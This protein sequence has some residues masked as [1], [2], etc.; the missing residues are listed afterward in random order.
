MTTK[1]IEQMSPQEARETIREMLDKW[2][3]CIGVAMR[4]GCS[5][6]QAEEVTGR[7]FS[8]KFGICSICGQ[9]LANMD[10][11]VHVGCL[12]TEVISSDATATVR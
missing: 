8:Y 2:E 6:V 5:R 1:G 3:Y 7:Y 9:R 11:N 4:Q 10:S 12:S